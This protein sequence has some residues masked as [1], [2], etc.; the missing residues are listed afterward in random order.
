MNPIHIVHHDSKT[1]SKQSVA[2]KREL[3]KLGITVRQEQFDGFKHIELALPKAKL[4]IEVDGMHHLTNP[5]QIIA[6][7]NRQYHSSKLGF[8]TIHISNEIIDKHLDKIANALAEVAK[9][10]EKE[11]IQ[12]SLRVILKSAE[13]PIAQN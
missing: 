12:S 6:D 8:A 5:E 2:L 10:R 9:I 13:I 1:P 11:R 4:N 3:E 7:L